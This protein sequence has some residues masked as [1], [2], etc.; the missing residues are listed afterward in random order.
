MVPGI[1]VS[2]RGHMVPSRALEDSVVDWS[3]EELFWIV[4]NGFKYTGMPAWPAQGR[5]DE[6]WAQVAFCALSRHTAA[7][8][9]I[10]PRWR[11]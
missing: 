4:K 1:A 6:V 11:L 7:T 9:A 10:L 3:D 2:G 5:D 8:Y